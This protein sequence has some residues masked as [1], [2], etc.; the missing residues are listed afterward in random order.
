MPCVSLA[1]RRIYRANITPREVKP[2][3]A[4]LTDL[5]PKTAKSAKVARTT[6]AAKTTRAAKAAKTAKTVQRSQTPQTSRPQKLIENQPVYLRPRRTPASPKRAMSERRAKR[7]VKKLAKS[8]QKS[9]R[10]LSRAEL[11]NAESALGSKLFGPI[12]AGHRREFFHDREN[13]WIWHEGWVD[14]DHHAHQL[15]VR[16]EVRPSGVYK[17]I[18]AGKYFRLEGEELANFR[19]ATRAY[20]NLV[21]QK[22]YHAA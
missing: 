11:I 6:K 19:R 7:I 8:G 2:V 10:R 5:Q 22:L 21:K 4:K 20:L 14:R 15:T 16:Y 13:I 18:A 17:K 1:Y 9:R 12:P 3:K